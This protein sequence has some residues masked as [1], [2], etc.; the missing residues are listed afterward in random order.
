MI[1]LT[2]GQTLMLAVI[3]AAFIVLM[4]LSI[5]SDAVER[6][7]RES[8]N[9]LLRELRDKDRDGY[10]YHETNPISGDDNNER[11]HHGECR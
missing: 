8:H 7:N 5:N 10:S 1:A 6:F 9:S 2:G 4:F 3:I 11:N